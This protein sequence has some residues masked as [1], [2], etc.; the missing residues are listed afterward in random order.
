DI[1]EGYKVS[2]LPKGKSFR[3]YIWGFDIQYEQK[4]NQIIMT[5]EFYNEHL[6]LQ[7]EHFKEWNEV[8]ENLFPQYKESISISKI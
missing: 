6:L 7:P 8:L 5:Q 2:Y 4:N 3:N 1:P